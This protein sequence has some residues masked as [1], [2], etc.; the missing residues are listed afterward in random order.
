MKM[1]IVLPLIAA[2]AL[3]GCALA[4]ANGSFI[5]ELPET[6]A[7]PI[8]TRIAE[9][10]AQRLPR[11]AKVL[12]V[13][14]AGDNAAS[15]EVVARLDEALLARGL[16]IASDHAAK[17]RHTL[18]YEVTPYGG[19][20]LVRVHLDDA[21]ATTVMTRRHDG[22]LIATSPLTVREAAR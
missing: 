21:E 1:R 13:R 8:S 11:G 7:V 12:P 16:V 14:A 20:W 15:R 19:A 9:L 18:R 4:R 5:A 2:V 10:A 17:D 3:S 22:M 6:D